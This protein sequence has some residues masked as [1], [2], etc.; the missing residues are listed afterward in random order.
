MKSSPRQ[1]LNVIKPSA[2]TVC[3]LLCASSLGQAGI[4]VSVSQ[5]ESIVDASL[6]SGSSGH[7]TPPS[8]FGT[9]N[10]VRHTTLVELNETEELGYRFSGFNS[11]KGVS[12]DGSLQ[13]FTITQDIDVTVEWTITA[14]YGEIY[15]FTINSVLGAYLAIQDGA[16]DEAG[17]VAQLTNLNATLKKNNVQIVVD[18]LGLTGGILQTDGTALVDD[19]VSRTFTDLIGTNTFSVTYTGQAIASWRTGGTFLNPADRTESAVL[20]GANGEVSGD[21]TDDYASYLD[22]LA[23]GLFIS[24]TVEVTAIPEPATTALLLAFSA[25]GLVAYRRRR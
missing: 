10:G 1:F 21:S 4:V 17:D 14:D 5:S 7:T 11:G 25:L 20:W 23:D 16:N 15:S 24:G 2:L 3:A 6:S 19:S 18:Q 13:T 9:T 12:S 22:R 8:L